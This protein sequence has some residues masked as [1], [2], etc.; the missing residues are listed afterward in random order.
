MGHVQYIEL[1]KLVDFFYSSEYDDCLP[2][3]ADISLL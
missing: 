3:E 2:E 1:K